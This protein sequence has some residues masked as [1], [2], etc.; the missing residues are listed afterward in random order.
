MDYSGGLLD[1]LIGF[2]EGRVPKEEY[3]LSCAAICT[4]LRSGV[5]LY[6]GKEYSSL[7]SDVQETRCFAALQQQYLYFE[8]KIRS[9]SEAFTKA[10]PPE[11]C[12]SIRENYYSLNNEL[13]DTENK[14]K[15]QKD[16]MNTLNSLKEE[17]RKNMKDFEDTASKLSKTLFHSFN[18]D[19]GSWRGKDW[20][21]K[22][23]QS[24][25]PLNNGRRKKF[26]QGGGS[27]S[28]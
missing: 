18:N 13:Q 19:T 27:T 2:L 17:V 25:T 15:D 7:I 6:S 5:F 9:L 21:Q 8:E 22:K 14:F 4:S 24:R 16:D 26:N 23:Y 3:R 11:T 28:E 10:Y 1:L 12:E 20:N